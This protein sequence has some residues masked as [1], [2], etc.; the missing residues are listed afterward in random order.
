MK[1][2]YGWHQQLLQGH[3]RYNGHFPGRR[4]AHQVVRCGF[5]ATNNE[6]EYEAV[7][8]GLR[9]AGDFGAKNNGLC[10]DSQHIVSQIRGEYLARDNRITTYLGTVQK[11][12]CRFDS[13]E[14]E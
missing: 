11:A 10:S 2:I 3:P 4:R 5:K 12:I 1:T 9:S 13:L 7:I 14:L 8:I 6:A